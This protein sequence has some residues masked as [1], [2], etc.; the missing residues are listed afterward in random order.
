MNDKTRSMTEIV[1]KYL[2]KDPDFL[3][4]HPEI[5]DKLNLPHESGEAVSLI[6]KQVQRLREQNRAL[7]RKLNQLVHVA[8]ENEALMTRLHQLTLELIVKDELG[9]FFDHLSE[10]LL[11][12]FKADILNITLFERKVEVGAKTPVYNL[13]RDDPELQQ[14]QE[15]LDK[16]E[17]L[18]G[19]LNRNKLDF[20]FRNRAQWVQ[21]TALVPL[22]KDGLLAIGSSD[23]AYFYPGMGTLFLDLLATVVTRRL[24]LEE[25]SKQRRSA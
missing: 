22:G 4:R 14:F 3:V 9:E 6:E 24:S 17:T 11:N 15:H 5:L 19:R 1:A 18:C 12:E 16:G 21:S 10:A 8:T 25:P 20:L 23:P 7:T 2:R 13:R